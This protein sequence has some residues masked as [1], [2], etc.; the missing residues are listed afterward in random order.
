MPEIRIQLHQVGS[1]T[2]EA[3]MRR[4]KVLVDRPEAKGGTDQGPMGGD[5][6]LAA[7]GGCFMSTL[8]AAIRT[9]E[10]DVSNVRTEVT[11]TLVENP[12]R[13]SAVSLEVTGD[14]ADHDLFKHLVDIAE[15]GCIMVNTL[16]GGVDF[17]VTTGAPV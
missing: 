7:V 16:K 11:G 17:A 8:L 6:F 5:Y 15:R 9:R 1:S 14:C 13:F 10:A 2:S 12:T 3:T 4:H